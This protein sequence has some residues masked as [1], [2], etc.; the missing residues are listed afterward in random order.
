[1]FDLVKR[2]REACLG[3]GLHHPPRL[4]APALHSPTTYPTEAQ[5][6]RGRGGSTRAS[7]PPGRH[8]PLRVMP[9][10]PAGLS[11][12]P[13]KSGRIATISESLKVAAQPP[14]PPS[15]GGDVGSRRN[16]AGD[17]EIAGLRAGKVPRPI[18]QQVVWCGVVWG[19]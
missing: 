2:R 19:E 5:P 3:E 7:P 13:A 4:R 6:R 12:V 11:V 18:G 15:A 14:Q 9:K 8:G 17:G 1:M 16:R 10:N